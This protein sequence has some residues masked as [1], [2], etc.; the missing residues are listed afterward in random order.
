MSY[1]KVEHC[2]TIDATELREL[3]EEI[4][5]ATYTG[6]SRDGYP[7]DFQLTRTAQ[8][9]LVVQLRSRRASPPVTERVLL[10]P[11]MPTFGGK[12][13]WFTCPGCERR[14]RVLYVPPAGGRFG[15]RRCLELRYRSQSRSLQEQRLKKIGRLKV[16][17]GARGH[18]TALVAPVPPRPK[19]MHRSTYR[20]LVGQLRALEDA[21][22]QTAGEYMHRRFGQRRRS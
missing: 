8:E 14:C 2:W 4:E 18:G 10:T 19:R 1:R 6:G 7:I 3:L 11:T 16:R 22:W 21:Y 12:R 20:K 5:H 17:L 15:C 9:I 13:W